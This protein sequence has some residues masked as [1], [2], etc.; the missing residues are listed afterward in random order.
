MIQE[1]I[2][3]ETEFKYLDN[4]ITI[5]AM[6]KHRMIYKIYAC[7]NFHELR[8]YMLYP[9]IWYLDLF[10]HALYLHE[11]HHVCKEESQ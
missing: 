11:I 7:L 9:V 6:E 10:W 4:Y 8:P 2:F 1:V 3:E 5:Q